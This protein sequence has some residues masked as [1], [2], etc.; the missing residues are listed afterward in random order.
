MVKIPKNCSKCGRKFPLLSRV[1]WHTSF[2]DE[3]GRPKPLCRECYSEIKK[4]SISKQVENIKSGIKEGKNKLGMPIKGMKD[5]EYRACM[6]NLGLLEG[7]EIKLQYVCFRHTIGAPSIWDG[8]RS[9]EQ[10]KGLLVFTNDNMIFM[11]QEGAWSCNYSQALRFPLEEISGIS[12]GGTFIKRLRIL[13]GTRGSSEYHEFVPFA[14]QGTISEIRHAI[15][16]L[17][18]EVRQEKKR[19]AQEA[20]AKGTVPVMI[21]CKFCGTRNKADQSHCANCGAPL[22]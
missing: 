9:I 8:Q 11:Q 15:E 18:T 6:D 19:L 1:Y 20:L 22:T 2:K 5:S 17:L 4:E 21:F 7:E 13:V 10:K 3:E 12:E 16:T 14:G